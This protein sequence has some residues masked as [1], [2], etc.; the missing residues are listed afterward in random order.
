MGSAGAA[1]ERVSGAEPELRT[2]YGPRNV[3]RSIVGLLLRLALR[4]HPTT[5][6]L[7]LECDPLLVPA[8]DG[9]H[10][11]GGR[12][13]GAQPAVPRLDG[14]PGPPGEHVVEVQR[15]FVRRCIS[16]FHLQIS[17]GAG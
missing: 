4:G 17:V 13:G 12:F 6:M 10:Q 9:R 2:L 16:D 11:A 14:D 8:E 3:R 15:G 5:V 1:G 7:D